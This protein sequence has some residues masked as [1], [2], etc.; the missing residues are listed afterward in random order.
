MKKWLRQTFS[1]DESA[2]ETV[3]GAQ[4]ATYKRLGVVQ[5]GDVITGINNKRFEFPTAQGINRALEAGWT[6]LQIKFAQGFDSLWVIPGVDYTTAKGKLTAVLLAKEK[7]LKDPAGAPL[8]LDQEN[9]LYQYRNWDASDDPVQFL[10]A[11]KWVSRQDFYAAQTFPGYDVFL[12]RSR[13]LALPRKGQ[14]GTINGRPDLAGGKTG[15]D[16]RALLDKDSYFM[17]EGMTTDAWLWYSTLCV[18]LT[19]TMPDVWSRETGCLTWLLA[20]QFARAGVVPLGY[21]DRPDRQVN[22]D[23]GDPGSSDDGWAARSVVRIPRP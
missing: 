20:S 15:R 8:L 17:E 3:L 11:N 19:D 22:L 23:G 16:Y 4:L 13:D 18:D 14:G 5:D 12:T 1:L 2:L 7:K 6:D 10:C 21:F 9:P